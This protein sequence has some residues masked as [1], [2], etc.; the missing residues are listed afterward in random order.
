MKLLF[1]EQTTTDK[2]KA[3]NEGRNAI[4]W[5]GT[6]ITVMVEAARF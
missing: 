2:V 5:Q 4:G 6:A 1:W 3:E